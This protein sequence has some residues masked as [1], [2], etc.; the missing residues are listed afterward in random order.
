M[1]PGNS[2]V[3]QWLG[4][5]TFTSVAQVQPLIR[6]LKFPQAARSSRKKNYVPLLLIFIALLVFLQNMFLDL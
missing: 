2:L 4:L 5:G 6:E 1:F 3:V